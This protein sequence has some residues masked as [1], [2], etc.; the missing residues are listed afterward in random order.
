MFTIE[1]LP[2][3]YGDCL[4]I[5][6]GAPD[7]RHHVLID[8]GPGHTYEALAARLT[9]EFAAL[10]ATERRV[11]LFVITHV[12]SDHIAGALELLVTNPLAVTFGDIWFNTWH[13]LHDAP[14]G[15]SPQAVA[16]PPA[17]PTP[18]DLLGPVEGEQLSAVLVRRQHQW[19]AAFNG[20]AV[21]VPPT[22]NLPCH[23][24]PGGLQ[25]TLLSPTPAQLSRLLS[26]WQTTVEDEGLVA[27]SAEAALAKL[28]EKKPLPAD[29]LADDGVPDPDALV[30]K[31]FLPDGSKPNGTSIV[32]LAEFESRSCLLAADAHADVLVR[33]G[34]RLRRER[35]VASLELDVFKLPHH[36]SKANVSPE[37]VKQFPA[38]RYLVSTNGASSSRHPNGEALARVV[39]HGGVGGQPTLIF[40][41]RTKYNRAWDADQLKQRFEYETVYPPDDQEGL[42]VTP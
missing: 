39:K 37:L 32:L 13:H 19:N 30:Q 18:H 10:P 5:T 1:M 4:W 3:A 28:R 29:L 40:N 16:A 8:G 31:P 2:A 15:D 20:Q 11:E 6:Y 9:A 26:E 24:L 25:L 14:G 35:G 12:D 34:A 17:A 27:G 23:T 22:G 36:G 33:T 41:Y 38:R 21:V 42:V 7:D